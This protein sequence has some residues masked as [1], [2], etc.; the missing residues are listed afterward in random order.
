MTKTLP[1]EV[2][3]KVMFLYVSVIVWCKFL[4]TCYQGQRPPRRNINICI[5]ILVSN[6]R[7][8]LPWFKPNET[9]TDKLDWL[10]HAT[11]HS[12]VRKY[13][14]EFQPEKNLTYENVSEH[15]VQRDRNWHHTETPLVDRITDTYKNITFPQTSFAGGNKKA[16]QWN[17][18]RPLAD[19]TECEQ[20]DRHDW[21]HY[22]RHS[23]SGW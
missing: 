8:T 16:F 6:T 10:Y 15:P 14:Q 4:S 12:E 22:L 18:N 1:N 23:V 7:L 20:E 19:N 2:W 17:A 11:L 3:G 13:I 5:N 9:E 21:K